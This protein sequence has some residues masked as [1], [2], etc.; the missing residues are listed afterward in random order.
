MGGKITN[1][2]L[3]KLYV[4]C[5]P[6][7]RE[8]FLHCDLRKFQHVDYV[9]KAWEVSKQ[10]KSLEHIY[11][12]HMLEH[13]TSAEVVL[14]LSDWYSALASGGSVYVVVPNLDFHI[15]QWLK[16]EWNE[17]NVTDVNSDASYGLAGLYGW[18]R[19]CDPTK[20]DYNESYWDVHKTGFNERRM[21]FL[22]KSAGFVNI[23][24]KIKSD[25]HLTA[26]AKKVI[27]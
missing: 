6:D 7:V 9:C 8:G 3:K 1:Q 13:L 14:T 5:G 18:Q 19:E 12:R 10:I 21:K 4:G 24:I 16:A 17:K 11:S 22:L 20:S 25:V 23:D 15:S 27:G 2:K 26:T